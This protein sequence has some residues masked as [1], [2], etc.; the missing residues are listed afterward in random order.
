M[1]ERNP[2]RRRRRRLSPSTFLLQVPAESQHHERRGM[3]RAP[4]N[5]DRLLW[6]SEETSDSECVLLEGE[7]AEEAAKAAGAPAAAVAAA[8]A[9][10]AQETATEKTYL[11]SPDKDEGTPAANACTEAFPGAQN[12]VLWALNQQVLCVQ[13]YA[14]Q[15]EMKRTSAAPPL[16]VIP[17]LIIAPCPLLL[18]DG[19]CTLPNCQFNHVGSREQP[20]PPP[21]PTEEEEKASS[22]HPKIDVLSPRRGDAPPLDAE[23]VLLRTRAL[24]QDRP[25]TLFNVPTLQIFEVS[26]L[27]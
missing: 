24:L 17:S 11:K 4:R 7:A 10:V 18:R 12:T 1:A 8:A 16:R 15:I 6:L 21:P 2:R 27:E 9:P 25:L 13:G 22:W 19:C 20:P 5:R 23:G 3:P 26:W 14:R